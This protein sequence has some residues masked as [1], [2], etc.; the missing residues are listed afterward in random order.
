MARTIEEIKQQMADTFMADADVQDKYGFAD[1]EQFDDHFS[2]V[3][4]E[5][6]IFY[7]VAVAIWTL[8]KI[9]D[10]HKADVEEALEVRQ[11]CT[12]RWYRDQI[13]A[14][15]GSRNEPYA[16]VCAVSS[17]DAGMLVKIQQGNAG[18]RQA[19]TQQQVSAISGW[20][21]DN[22]EAGVPYVLRSA[23]P[24][25]LGGTVTVYYDPLVDLY[26]AEDVRVKLNEF[27]SDIPY[28]GILAVND[29]EA[30]L[31]ALP[32]IRRVKTANL[33]TARHNGTAVPVNVQTT[34]YSGSWKL[35]TG[36]SI[37]VTP[38]SAATI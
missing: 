21:Q 24:D 1:G 37:I 25:I 36:F 15:R 20:L 10:T 29:I 3:S 34:S 6:L 11:P 30:A 2:K 19:C 33:T 8:E 22:H 26:G 35:D 23:P 14:L 16:T 7:I 12:A 27:L 5:N 18:A 17:E 13:L 32:G 4:L 9:F 28:D 38:Y 31:L